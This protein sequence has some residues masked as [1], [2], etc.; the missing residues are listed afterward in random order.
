MISSGGSL[1]RE[2]VPFTK[3]MKSSL[4]IDSYLAKSDGQSIAGMAAAEVLEGHLAHP[5]PAVA[6]LLDVLDLTRPPIIPPRITSALSATGGQVGNLVGRQGLEQ[7]A[8][9]VRGWLVM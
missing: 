3:P 2:M 5:G 1:R 6:A 8:W 4:S 9:R 7:G